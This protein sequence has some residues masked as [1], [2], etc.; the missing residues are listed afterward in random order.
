M[1]LSVPTK[2]RQSINSTIKSIFIK[3][4]SVKRF[5]VCRNLFI[6]V[7]R[8]F[9]TADVFRQIPC[10]QSVKIAVQEGIKILITKG[11]IGD[12]KMD[13]QT[14]I[15]SNTQNL[16]P[17]NTRTIGAP[18]GIYILY[19][20]DYVHTFIKKILSVEDEKPHPE[21]ALYGR[22]VEES[23][24]FRIV[25]SGAAALEGGG[26]RIQQLNNTYFP[27][28]AY[29]GNAKADYNK[30][31]K[32]RIELTLRS[33]KVILD[34]F[35]IY[36]DQNEEMQNYLVEWNT[37]RDHD[38][39]KV[40]LSPTEQEPLSRA[41][42]KDAAHLSR[43]TQAYNREEAKIGFMWNVMNVLCLGFVVCIMAY[44]IISMNNYNKMQSMQKNIDYCLAFVAE[45]TSLKMTGQEAIPTMQQSAQT[46]KEAAAQ[47]PQD[48][49]LTGTKSEQ[50]P[51]DTQSVKTEQP[52]DSSPAQQPQDEPVSEPAQTPQQAAQQPQDMPSAEA[53][54]QPQ[55]TLSAETAQPSQDMASAVQSDAAQAIQTTQS[56]AEEQTHETQPDSAQVLAQP[57]ADPAQTLTTPQY[58]VVRK[59]DTLRTIC[60]EIYGDYSRVEEI[61]QWNQI[62]NPDNI[63]YGQKLL[64]P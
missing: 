3:S 63:L 32:L 8:F 13:K 46:E 12:T 2:Q 49:S 60:Y 53:A 16:I 11:C 51:Q 61:C 29:I 10:V 35:Y 24:R 23:G 1:G 56:G 14:N 25:V 48:V 42:V 50:Q 28:C 34:D 26:D 59:G 38:K 30:D 20:E 7:E 55:N 64:L 47:S 36:Y 62:E 41:P 22:S 33:T 5:R 18:E 17:V 9:L 57:E 27:S 45:N 31:L 54:Q 15:L 21:I 58:Y 43:I 19:L 37:M 39:N 40:I 4:I 44:G 52:H 6:C